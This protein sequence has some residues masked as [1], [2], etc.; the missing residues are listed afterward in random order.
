M[1][2]AEKEIHMTPTDKLLPSIN[3]DGLYLILRN[4][5]KFKH[6][7]RFWQDLET[8][9]Y[10]ND[11]RKRGDTRAPVGNAPV[12]EV[13]PSSIYAVNLTHGN[14]QEWHDI[15]TAPR[16]GTVILI[17]GRE[18]Q[19]KLVPY[20]AKWSKSGECWVIINGDVEIDWEKI[21]PEKWMPILPFREE[22]AL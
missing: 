14:L 19:N 15:S 21:W 13:K 4:A 5:Q 8:W 2:K 11:P 17:L 6:K 20:V 10:N 9:L 12:G 18:G 1:R 22:S 7:D 16:D 3:W